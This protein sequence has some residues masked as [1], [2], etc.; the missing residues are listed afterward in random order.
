MLSLWYNWSPCK[1]DI[2]TKP[3]CHSR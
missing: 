1:V 2:F 3:C